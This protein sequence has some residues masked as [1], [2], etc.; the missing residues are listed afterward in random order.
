VRR[1]LVLFGGIA[2]ACLLS[3][4][5]GA[6]QRPPLKHV[7]IFGDS[8]AAALNWDSQARAEVEK[9]NRVLY[10][11]R[12]CGRLTTPGCISPPPPSV[13]SEVRTLG[14][15]VGPTVM[16]HVGY[17]DD[18]HVYANGIDS[19][20]R[21][22]RNKG[23]KHVL[24]LT[25][26]TAAHVQQYSATNTV[27][28]GASHRWPFMTVVAWGAYSRPHPEWFTDGIHFTS[29]GAVQFGIFLH[30]TLRKYGLTGPVGS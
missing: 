1:L 10:E 17:N 20:L 29:S 26:R 19:V 13:L 27:I 12:P 25:L 16:V 3:A 2:I 28:R 5:A 6:N 14:R 18:P 9:G 22:M 23:V 7:T 24:W 15:R 21:A 8:S 4:T 11:L 30:R